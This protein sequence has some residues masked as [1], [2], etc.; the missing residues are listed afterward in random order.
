MKAKLLLFSCAVAICCSSAFA[1]NQKLWA[2]GQTGGAFSGGTIVSMNN[3]GTGFCVAHSF[4][5]TYGATPKGNLL[6]ASD[7]NLYGNCYDGGAFASC[8]IFRYDPQTGTY[9]DVW[10]YDITNGDFPMSGLVE[11]GNGKL[12]GACSAGGVGGGVIYSYDLATSAYTNLYAFNSTTGGTPYGA[13][14]FLG[15]QLYGMTVYGGDYNHGV[16]YSFNPSTNTYVDLYDFD[17]LLNGGNPYGSLIQGSDGSLYGM[18]SIGGQGSGGVIFKFNLV[19]NTFSVIHDFTTTSGGLT[20]YA[21]LMQGMDGKLYGTTSAGGT[22]GTGAIFSYDLTTNTYA[23]LYS[24]TTA[25]GTYPQG[26]LSQDNN[27][28]IFGTTSAGGTGDGN[29]FR[30]DPSTGICTSFMNFSNTTSGSSPNGSALLT[31]STVGINKPAAEN[32]A[33]SVFPNPANDVLNITFR[34][35]ENKDA[36][37]V[38]SNILGE[39]FISWNVDNITE[40]YTKSMDVSALADGVYFLTIT[41]GEEKSVQKIIIK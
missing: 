13:P 3:N 39:E 1:Q 15:N 40:T 11:A 24:F 19:G 30:F 5:W 2:Y 7:G 6:L 41:S 34:P 28:I 31:A 8:V 26:D 20:P 25:T 4:D 27:G 17:G 38:L 10:D 16:I 18:T 37:F 14:V 33:L 21:S 32:N 22:N 12:Y 29:I 35:G 23:N 36:H 9:T